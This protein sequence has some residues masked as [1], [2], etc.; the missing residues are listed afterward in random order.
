M[1]DKKVV[2]VISQEPGLDGGDAVAK[3]TKKA[4]KAAN[5]AGGDIAGFAAAVPDGA[6]CAPGGI[7]EAFEAGAAFVYTEAGKDAEACMSAVM[8]A[9]DRRTMVVWAGPDAVWFGGLGT[10]KGGATDRKVAAADIIPTISYVTDIPL[11]GGEEGAVIYQVLKDPNLK[12]K[13]INRLKDAVARMEAAM[14]RAE[15][16]DPWKKH[17]CA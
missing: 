16:H 10:R 4:A 8:A 3:F 5:Y 1:A 2:L 17:D 9:I 14:E 6:A 15:G 11:T 13:E 12:A 7:N